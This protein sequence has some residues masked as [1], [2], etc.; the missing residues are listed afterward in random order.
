MREKIPAENYGQIHPLTVEEWHHWLMKNH[1]SVVG[2]WL[3]SWKII[4]G[5]PRFKEGEAIEE[6]LYWGWIDSLPRALDAER[7]MLLFTPRKLQSN[8][9][10]INKE[11]A[12]RMIREGRMMAA[13]EAKIDYAKANGQWDALNAVEALAIPADL[14]AAFKTHRGSAT[15]FEAFPKSAKRGILEWIL[16]AKTPVTRAK[17]VEETASLAAQNI[18]AN[19]WR[20]KKP[21]R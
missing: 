19:Q 5:K 14:A 16:N 10:A 17:R 9:S 1:T 12:T 8:W 13:G 6:A 7:S 3:V 15:L 4:T 21:S 20:M 18:R 2:I 11:R